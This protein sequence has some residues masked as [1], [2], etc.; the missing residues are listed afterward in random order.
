MTEWEHRFHTKDYTIN[1]WATR[2]QPSKV[3]ANIGLLEEH[4]EA[5]RQIDINVLKNQI[6]N[7]TKCKKLKSAVKT[8][9][10]L[11]TEDTTA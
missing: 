3:R 4:R 8:L 7:A 11:V 6:I 10:E 5:G 9:G 1:V 2:E